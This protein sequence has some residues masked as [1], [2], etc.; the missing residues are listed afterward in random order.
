MKERR[1]RSEEIFRYHELQKV[2][3][4]RQ[5]IAAAAQNL[6]LSIRQVKRISVYIE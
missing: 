1:S 6:S 3:E 5:T 4:K 2:H